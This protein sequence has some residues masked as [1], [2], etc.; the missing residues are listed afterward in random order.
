MRRGDKRL[1]PL[2]PAA[3]DERASP[4]PTAARTLEA[5]ESLGGVLAALATLPAAQREV[6]RLKFQEELSYRDIAE[7]TGLT[8]NHVGVLIHN[9][10][11]SLRARAQDEPAAFLR[12][13]R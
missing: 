13:V 3:L 1:S 12:R 10:L 7:V 5:R 4:E 11:K 9:G 2:E 8:V 6:L